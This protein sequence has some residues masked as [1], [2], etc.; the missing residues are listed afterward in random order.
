MDPF[1]C[2]KTYISIK[3]HF[4]IDNYDYHK[5]GGKSRATIQ[6]FYKRKD[7]FWFEKLSRNKIDKEIVD[8]FVANFVS[9]DDP[10]NLWIGEI[11]HEGEVKYKN[12]MKRIQ[13]LSYFF[14]EEINDIFLNKNFDE[15]FEIKNNNHPILLKNYFQ[16][17]IS[18]ESMIILDNILGYKKNFDKKLDDPIWK[19][20]SMRMSKYSSFLHIDIFKYKKI[21]KECVL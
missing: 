12:W 21:L 2:Y 7:R 10:E 6:S 9:C 16:K 18:L 11:I 15:I 13:S 5:Y 20:V 17:K 1:S 8:F 19:F 3:N 14:N 4:T